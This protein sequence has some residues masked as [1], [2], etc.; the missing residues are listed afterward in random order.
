MIGMQYKIT[1]PGDY[2]MDIIKKRV[3]ENGYKTDGFKDLLFKCYLIQDKN[4]DGF[5]NTYAPLYVWKDS[6]G[7]NEFIFDGYYDNILHS[8]GWQ[9]I[10]I[11]IPLEVDLSKHYVEARYMLE[12]SGEINARDSLKD[13]RESLKKS[14][15]EDPN[16]CGT[17]CIYN[18]DKWRYSQFLFLKN[19][20]QTQENDMYHIYQILHISEG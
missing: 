19:R 15:Q 14:V 1:L 9:N 17:V 7:M 6:E 5:E 18:P 2:D 10:N 12:T 16:I 4:L 3:K 20:P 13:V 8:F 11:G